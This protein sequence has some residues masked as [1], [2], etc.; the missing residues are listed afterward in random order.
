MASWLDHRHG[1]VKTSISQSLTRRQ[2]P[3][4]QRQ[5][6]LEPNNMM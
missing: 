3:W 6:M 1:F 2:A 4:R 5:N